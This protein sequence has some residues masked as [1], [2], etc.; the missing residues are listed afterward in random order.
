M[1]SSKMKGNLMEHISGAESI[2]NEENLEEVIS[3]LIKRAFNHPKG[4]SDFINIKLEEISK[5]EIT[6]IEPLPVTTVNVENYLEGFNIVTNILENMG[7]DKSKSDNIVR[8]IRSI[9][10][11]RGAILLDINTFQRL[12]TDKQRGIRATY[13]G[14]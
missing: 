4:K 9:S 3:L 1:R 12:E 2:S 8:T 14:F 11:M 6:Y 10:N 13:M 7:I 5:E